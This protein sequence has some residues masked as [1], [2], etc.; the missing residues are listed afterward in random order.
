MANTRVLAELVSQYIDQ[1]TIQRRDAIAYAA[2]FAGY[3]PQL[4]PLLSLVARI[5]ADLVR[6]EPP[7]LFREQLRDRLVMAARQRVLAAPPAPQPWIPAPSREV[8]I[9]AAAVGSIVS[10]AAIFMVARSRSQ[11]VKR[12]A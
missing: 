10:V 12:A 9:G 6:Q 3:R 1:A 11:A 8:L 5:R 2:V 4:E 7:A